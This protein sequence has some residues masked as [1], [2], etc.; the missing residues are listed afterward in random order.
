VKARAAKPKAGVGNTAALLTDLSRITL[1]LKAGIFYTEILLTDL[2]GVTAYRTTAC[3]LANSIKAGLSC[4]TG[5]VSTSKDALSIAAE[6]GITTV[7]L[8]ARVRDTA[9]RAANFSI[10]TTPMFTVINATN[11]TPT[12]L[13]LRAA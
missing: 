13:P 11:S 6:A 12:N 5:G 2:L 8:C 1:Q 3:L 4:R 10:R 9:F 7:Y